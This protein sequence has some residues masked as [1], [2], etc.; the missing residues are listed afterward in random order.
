MASPTRPLL[1]T[2]GSNLPNKETQQ[3]A[4]LLALVREVADAGSA[5]VRRAVDAPVVHEGAGPKLSMI[6]MAW[7]FLVSNLPATG[8]PRW[9]AC[10]G[11]AALAGERVCQA[12][13]PPVRS[14]QLVQPGH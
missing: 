13:E 12:R 10:S 3:R 5:I 2:Q 8:T 1:A 7:A 9:Q 6:F 4:E 14:Q 11:Q